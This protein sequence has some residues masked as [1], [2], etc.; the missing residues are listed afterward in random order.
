MEGPP[1][2]KNPAASAEDMDLIPGLGIKIPQAA[3]RM[4]QKKK[5]KELSLLEMN[6]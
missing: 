4:G 6:D 5:K 1:V 3:A 2:V